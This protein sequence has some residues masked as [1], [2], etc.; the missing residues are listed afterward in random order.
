MDPARQ[1][2]ESGVIASKGQ[3]LW[4]KGTDPSAQ[5]DRP[6]GSIGQ[7]IDKAGHIPGLSLCSVLQKRGQFPAPFFRLPPAAF[8]PPPV[9]LFCDLYVLYRTVRREVV[10]VVLAIESTHLYIVGRALLDA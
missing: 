3:T 2:A 5:R 1:E 6:F 8:H 9:R 10:D 4:L 7:N